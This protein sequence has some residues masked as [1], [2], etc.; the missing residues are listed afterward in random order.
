M[1]KVIG[2]RAVF[3]LVMLC[4]CL[5][6]YTEPAPLHL[7]SGRHKIHLLELYSSQSCSSCPPAERWVSQFV[8]DNR[9]WN[10]IIPMVFHVDYWDDLGWQD[11]FAKPQYTLRQRQY[12]QQGK[13]NAVYTPGFI[14][15]GIEWR[16][17]FSNQSVSKKQLTAFSRKPAPRLLVDI[18][19][20]DITAQFT[21][22]SLEPL[23]LN[24]A[25]LGFD[26]H[27]S[28]VEGENSGL[29][30]TQNFLVLDHYA[31]AANRGNWQLTL[32]AKHYSGKKAIVLWVTGESQL[33]PL[34]AVGGWL[35]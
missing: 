14:V 5:L 7:D 35:P 8:S 12:Q 13:I 33:T 34:Q 31:Y 11:R 18:E 17:W 25:I 22:D 20:S 1:Q 21:S 28:I 16:Q 26:L 29:N 24:I 4:H 6:A 2:T 9:L 27:T 30:L 3:T 23:L 32:P 15:D 10:T 19:H